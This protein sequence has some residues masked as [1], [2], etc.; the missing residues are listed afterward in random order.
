MFVGSVERLCDC[1]GID[2]ISLICMVNIYS[3]AGVH[4]AVLY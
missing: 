4:K 1:I 2:L 3:Y